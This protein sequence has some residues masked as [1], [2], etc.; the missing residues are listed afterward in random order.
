MSSATAKRWF[1]P[2]DEYHNMTEDYAFVGET[3]AKVSQELFAY[4]NETEHPWTTRS[5]N[6][7]DRLRDTDRGAGCYGS[8]G[9]GNILV[10][11]D[12]NESDPEHKKK[13]YGSL[14]KEVCLD[15][16]NK[17]AE[18]KREE[19]TKVLKKAGK[20]KFDDDDDYED[21]LEDSF[22]AALELG[23]LDRVLVDGIIQLKDEGDM[24]V[25]L[26]FLSGQTKKKTSRPVLLLIGM[27][28]KAETDKRGLT[29]GWA[30]GYDFLKKILII[31]PFIS[32]KGH[33]PLGEKW[34]DKVAN[35]G[36]SFTGTAA[37]FANNFVKLAGQVGGKPEADGYKLLVH[38]FVSHWIMGQWEGF[39]A[40]EPDKWTEAFEKSMADA[41][42]TIL[43]SLGERTV[44]MKKK[45]G[46]WK[47]P[48]LAFDKLA[49]ELA[50]EEG[51]FRYAALDARK[52]GNEKA[53]QNAADLYDR[54]VK[55]LRSFNENPDNQI[56][57]TDF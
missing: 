23:T 5:K 54:M 30:V 52:K 33:H 50:I 26:N 14:A 32:K 51:A 29:E 12:V 41:R 1:V 45:S 16:E 34:N 48:M 24:R 17:K 40:M 43:A 44:A 53:A 46:E 56:S 13:V 19:L 36:I 8:L 22:G 21:W 25:L 38:T 6:L 55:D 3:A 20:D 11:A 49:N 4:D 2:N 47:G 57:A 18:A 28:D 27:I 15:K 7:R 31:K 9:E 37:L 39:S 42:K 35:D 10:Y